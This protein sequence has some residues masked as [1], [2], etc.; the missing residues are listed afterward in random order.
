VF[1]RRVRRRASSV[2]ASSATMV[3]LLLLRLHRALSPCF[4]LAAARGLSGSWKLLS[5]AAG[6][7]TLGQMV[8]HASV[9]VRLPAGSGKGALLVPGRSLATHVSQADSDA[10]VARPKAVTTPTTVTVHNAVSLST[11]VAVQ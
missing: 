3:A 9:A 8:E 6:N 4:P 11:T 5:R 1:G 7:F 2:P 10:C